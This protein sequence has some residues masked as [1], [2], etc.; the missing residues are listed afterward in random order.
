MNKLSKKT[1]N[2]S[3]NGPMLQ[4]LISIATNANFADGNIIRQ[5]IEKFNE[6]RNECVD[7]I[8]ELTS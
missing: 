6:F 3:Q 4:A 5:I 2:R 7:A 1:L 8:N